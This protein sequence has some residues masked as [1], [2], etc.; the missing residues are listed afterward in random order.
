[1]PDYGRTEFSP[2][3]EIGNIEADK[4]DPDHWVPVYRNPAF[5]NML[6]DD[7]YWAAKIVHAFTD[8]DIRALVETGEYRD[9]LSTDYLTRTLIAR[10]DKIVQRYFSRVLPLDRF[11]IDG[12]QLRCD[13]LGVAAK[14]NPQR[15]LS[16]Q[17][18]SFDNGTGQMA[19]LAGGGW[20]VPPA[21]A[22]AAP[23]SYFGVEIRDTIS[24]LKTTVYRRAS[25]GAQEVVGLDRTWK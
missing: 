13:D 11:R 6:P 15:Q 2:L 20:R 16:T 4:F 1:V 5:D 22:T 17:W 23:G 12:G 19:P 7:A 25:R 8:A 14:L 24:G 9:P 10:R 3:K 18:F 21:V